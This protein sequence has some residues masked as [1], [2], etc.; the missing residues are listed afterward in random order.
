MF[1][2]KKQVWC[3]KIFQV[4]DRVNA[5]GSCKEAVT[6]R[7]RIGWVKFKEC[8][9]SLINPDKNWMNWTELQVI[10]IVLKGFTRL[11]SCLYL[12]ISQEKFKKLD[13]NLYTLTDMKANQH[14][15]RGEPDRNIVLR[16]LTYQQYIK[17]LR[18]WFI[19]SAFSKICKK[20]SLK[21]TV[22]KILK[23]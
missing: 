4:N 7:A 12:E 2:I 14:S 5:S 18:P 10:I 3:Y 8:G 22:F 17:L 9:E 23:F 6:A 21:Y 15:H 19:R 16:F 20:L 1:W 11:C 13:K